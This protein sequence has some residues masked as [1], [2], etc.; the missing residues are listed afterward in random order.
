MS[1]K[2]QLGK[3]IRF[4]RNKR[5][6]TQEQLAEA[7]NIHEKNISK[8]ENGKNFPSAETLTA[9]AQA[10]GVEYY[11]LFSFGSEMDYDKMKEEIINSLNNKQ[12]ILALYECLKN[13]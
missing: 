5:N 8:I 4:Y 10:L 13:I 9:I 7:V 11:E 6:L 2:E 3:S 12:T 1:L